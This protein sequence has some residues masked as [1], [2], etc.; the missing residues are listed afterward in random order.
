MFIIEGNSTWNKN[1]EEREELFE[2]ERNHPSL[3]GIAMQV[4]GL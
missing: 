1:F 3:L 4:H 2:Q